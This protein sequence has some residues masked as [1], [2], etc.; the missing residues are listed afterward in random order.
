MTRRLPP[1]AAI[2]ASLAILVAACG[3]GAT[4][5]ELTDPTAIVTAALK[6]TEAAKS[7]H[8]DLTVDG[9]ATVKLP[10]SSAG[11]AIELTGTTAKADIDFA[12]KA[13]HLT[14]TVPKLLGFSG[15]VIAVDGT[16]LNQCG[17]PA[18]IVMKSPFFS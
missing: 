4:G 7:V 14:F 11:T 3:G 10:G 18:G 12:N 15:E 6:S 1:I 5:P 8:L 16:S 2:A 17:T 13:T 9:S